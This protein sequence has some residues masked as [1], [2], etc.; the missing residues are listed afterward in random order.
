M[1]LI[2]AML[3]F[4][5]ISAR[6]QQKWEYACIQDPDGYTYIRNSPSATT[7]IEDKVE[8]YLIFECAPGPDNWWKVKVP[9]IDTELEGYIHKS[10][11]R[12]MK[13]LPD[14]TVRRMILQTLQEGL[15]LQQIRQNLTAKRDRKDGKF[16]PK[17]NND[18][19]LA[20]EDVQGFIFARY[21]TLQSFLP[22]YICRTKD[23]L[24]MRAYFWPTPS[25]A[26]H[27]ENNS[28]ALSRC[29]LCHPEWV[30]QIVR[31]LPI[32]DQQ[33]VYSNLSRWLKNYDD[34][35]PARRKQLEEMIPGF[36][37]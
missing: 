29:F 15:R 23:S 30:M 5:S 19:L 24:V 13:N 36:V 11:I 25:K 10:R 9:A 27:F 3:L 17:D 16:T 31:T 21:I 37:K 1:R 33:E 28:P 18:L 12:L 34:L 32:K 8:P 2:L 14:T 35:T 22:E 4:V 26:L 6:G 20:S 7:G